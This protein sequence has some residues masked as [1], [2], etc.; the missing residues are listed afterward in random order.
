VLIER[1]QLVLNSWLPLMVL[2]DEVIDVDVL[3]APQV[4][5]DVSLAWH[6]R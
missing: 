5:V 3:P 1:D 2:T 4:G 6:F